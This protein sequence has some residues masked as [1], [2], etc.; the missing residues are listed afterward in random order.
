VFFKELELCW[1]CFIIISLNN[2][3]IIHNTK[4]PKLQNLSHNLRACTAWRVWIAEGRGS[5]KEKPDGG[6]CAEASAVGR[7][8]ARQQTEAKEGKH[9]ASQSEANPTVLRQRGIRAPQPV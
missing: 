2:G 7:N 4:Q 9:K 8:E 1:H 5:R 6:E 3:N